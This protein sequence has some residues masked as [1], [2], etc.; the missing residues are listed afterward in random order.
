[1]KILDFG[2]ATH[3][4][5]RVAAASDD[6]VLSQTTSGVVLGTPAYM[7]PEQVRA[8][9]VD[10][11]SDLF[12]FGVILF[13][14]VSGRRPFTGRSPVETMNAIVAADPPALAELSVPPTPGLESII[15][16]LLEK[17]P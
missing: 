2:I 11:R 15:R 6:T 7:S 9:H 4:M 17:N 8:E 1:V 16:R 3:A 10:H 13:E 12:S 14:M 5:P